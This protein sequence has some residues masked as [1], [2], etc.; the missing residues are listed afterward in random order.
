M[1][2]VIA[3]SRTLMALFFLF[4]AINIHVAQES[5]VKCGQEAMDDKNNLDI[6]AFEQWMEERMRLNP[7]GSARNLLQI[8]VIVHIIHR[9]ETIGSGRNLSQEQVLSQLEVLNEDFQRLPNTN[10]YNEHPASAAIGISFC[11]AQQDE[12]GTL[13][14]EAGIHRYE[15]NRIQWTVEEVELELKAQTYWNPD[16]YF[17]IWV[18]DLAENEEG[19][20]LGYAQFPEASGL[21]GIDTDTGPRQTDGVVI[22]YQ[23]FGS[24]EKGNFSGLKA[25]FNLG[26]V[27]THET[28]HWLG[29]RHI[30]GDGNCGADDYCEDTPPSNGPNYDC[31]RSHF[32]CGSEDMVE[33]YMDYTEDAC[34]NVFTNDQKSRMLTVLNNSPRRQRLLESDACLVPSTTNLATTDLKLVPNPTIGNVTM[35]LQD[36]GDNDQTLEFTIRITNINGQL[37]LETTT[38]FGEVLEIDL[39]NYAPGIYLVNVSRADFSKSWKLAKM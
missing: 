22:D 6:I 7:I 16:R 13:L 8:P 2:Y 12:N 35:N 20:I 33:N 21:S 36:N 5:W 24:V 26:R 29:L 28:G 38:L 27:A 25:P 3:S 31:D 37:L 9:G 4:T 34:L 10:G 11:P 1:K 30:W 18:V 39:T 32:S 17:N 15:G 19:T 14:E 23:Y